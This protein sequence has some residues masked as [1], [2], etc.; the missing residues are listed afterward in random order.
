M[1]LFIR[2][3]QHPGRSYNLSSESIHIG[4][5]LNDLLCWLPSSM[6]SPNLPQCPQQMLSRLKAS[7]SSGILEVPCAT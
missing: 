1:L 5:L 3:L 2:H 4:G 7:L 6:S